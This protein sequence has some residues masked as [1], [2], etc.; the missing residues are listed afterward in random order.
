MYIYIYIYICRC[1]DNVFNVMSENSIVT[2]VLKCLVSD[3]LSVH[4]SSLLRFTSQASLLS[5]RY[6]KSTY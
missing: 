3:R 5:A 4:P 6:A 2:C 1:D